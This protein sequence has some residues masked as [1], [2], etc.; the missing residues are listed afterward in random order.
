MNQANQE[1]LPAPYRRA[2]LW[3]SGALVAGL[4]VIAGTT[5][6]DRARVHK[7]EQFTE[8]TGVGDT[9]Y[10][11]V[12]T[13]P[14]KPPVAAATLNG[15][16]LFPVSYEMLDPRDTNML[17]VGRDDAT[18][19]TVYRPR[20]PLKGEGERPR[21][22]FYYLKTAPNRYLKVRPGTPGA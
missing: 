12:P 15:Q 18:G 22:I 9:A 6:I 8:L 3:I 16:L 1:Q 13:T 21:E 4:A 7:L 20:K 17:R 11:V 14:L 19:L 10:F 5:A 2:A